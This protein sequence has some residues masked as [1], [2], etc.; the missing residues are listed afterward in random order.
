M[1]HRNIYKH[2]GFEKG[3][4]NKKYQAVLEHKLDKSKVRVPFGHRKFEQFYDKIGSF[5]W[6]NHNDP[7][8][9]RLYHLRHK[10]R[11]DDKTHWTPNFFSRNFLW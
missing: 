8:R 4:G 2:T 11:P 10:E 6:L 9:R 5:R 3:K 1:Y 7:E